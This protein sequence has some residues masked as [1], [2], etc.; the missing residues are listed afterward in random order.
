MSY[1]FSPEDRAELVRLLGQ[2]GADRLAEVVELARGEGA[3]VHM[4]PRMAEKADHWALIHMA[5]SATG[6]PGSFDWARTWGGFMSED[7]RAEW[8]EM[9]LRL[10]RVAKCASELAGL[11]S[12]AAVAFLAAKSVTSARF[13]GG[14]R[15][16]SVRYP[17][18]PDPETARRWS[19]RD[20]ADF[21]EWFAEGPDT[22]RRHS[23]RDLRESLL[24]LSEWAAAAAPKTKPGAPR[25]P[26]R[27]SLLW[28][29]IGVCDAAGL[30]R[31]TGETAALVKVARIAFRNAEPKNKDAAGDPRD[32]L[33]A[34]KDA[35]EL[36]RHQAAS[37]QLDRSE[38]E[39]E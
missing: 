35:G 30:R 14:P 32:M 12:P 24:M 1:K 16:P 38:V 31:A 36:R 26:L 15:E 9:A 2:G 21:R 39:G 34:L 6:R 28:A 10:R 25:N 23:L 7:P 27:H 33:R 11:L 3:H 17:R 19:L 22:A 18:A 8:R 37:R 5:E 13:M 20:A 29:V 4:G